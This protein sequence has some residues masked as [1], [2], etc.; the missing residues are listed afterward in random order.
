M[1]KFWKKTEGFT[2]VELIVVIA[3]LGILAGIGTVGYSG[4]VKKANMAADQQLISDVMQAMELGTYSGTLLDNGYVLLTTEKAHGSDTVIAAMDAVFGDGWED[5]LQLAYNGWTDTA[6]LLQEVQGNEYAASVPGSSYIANV[7][8]EKLLGDVQNCVTQFSGLLTQVAGG[9]SADVIK[10]YLSNAEATALDTFLGDEYKN[11]DK[12]SALSNATVIAV[13]NAV[14]RDK[15]DIITG[16]TSLEFG[17][18][19]ATDS[20]YDKH[21]ADGATGDKKV[22]TTLAHKYAAMEAFVAYMDD[23]AAT[24]ILNDLNANMGTGA[25]SVTKNI[26]DAYMSIFQTFSTDEDKVAKMAAYYQPVDGGKSQALQ[27]AEA[28]IS[29]METVNNLSGDYKAPVHMENANLF[30]SGAVGNRVNAY[31]AA[32]TLKDALENDDMLKE[33]AAAGYE[34]A[35]VIVVASKQANG[36]MK[37]QLCASEA[38]N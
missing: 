2:L 1:K 20:L 17:Q 19:F 9:A 15:Q 3:I 31:V 25:A 26:D 32:A 4:Y 33:I 37:I 16:F 5:T 7:G 27:D 10:D 18:G 12:A 34:G 21:F 36:Q 38:I 11:T 29:M 22:L 24:Q 23:P 35:S 30:T 8:T 28:Y 14:A 6:T 13:S